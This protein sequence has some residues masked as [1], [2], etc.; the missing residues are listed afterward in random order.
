MSRNLLLT[1]EANI[2]GTDIKIDVDNGASRSIINMETY[3]T[4]KR[5][6]DSLT[7]TNSKL[8]T[9]SG[10]VI[11]AEGVIGASFKSH[12]LLLISKVHIYYEEM[13]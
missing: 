2:N 13:F 7:Y 3:K 6:A 9:F 1:A 11:K 4:I 10:D 12:L 5:K 8:R